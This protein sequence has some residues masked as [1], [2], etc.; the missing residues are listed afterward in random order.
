M[1]EPVLTRLIRLVNEDIRFLDEVVKAC[2]ELESD[3]GELTPRECELIDLLEER[4]KD[5]QYEMR[6]VRDDL[7]RQDG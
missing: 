6:Q 2:D 1:N 4:L 5:L 7:I 3:G